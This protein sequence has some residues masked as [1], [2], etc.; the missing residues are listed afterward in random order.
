MLIINN[1]NFTAFKALSVQSGFA[2]M[3]IK[4]QEIESK[5]L[6]LTKLQNILQNFS[7]FDSKTMNAMINATNNINSLKNISDS[8]TKL[9]T[10]FYPFNLSSQKFLY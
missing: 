6:G 8:F 2:K 10:L 5:L 7:Q 1:S 3:M 9:A 4:Q